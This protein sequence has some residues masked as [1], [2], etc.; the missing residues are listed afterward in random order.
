MLWTVR[1]TCV[2]VLD[3]LDGLSAMRARGVSRALHE[4]FDRICWRGPR[5]GA[6]IDLDGVAFDTYARCVRAIRDSGTAPLWVRYLKPRKCSSV[7]GMLAETGCTAAVARIG[8]GPPWSSS[9]EEAR[10]DANF[11]LRRACW[12]G[13]VGVVRLL[14]GPPWSLGRED[15]VAPRATGFDGDHALRSACNSGNLELLALLAGPPWNLGRADV[16]DG[17][18]LACCANSVDAMRALAGPPWNQGQDDA[19][20]HNLL[21]EAYPFPEVLCELARPPWLLGEADARRDNARVLRHVCASDAHMATL[22]LLGGPPWNLGQAD[23]RA[24]RCLEHACISGSLGIMRVLGEPPWSLGPEDAREL[25]ASRTNW[26]PA[27]RNALHRPPYAQQCP[28]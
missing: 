11:A 13:H 8:A 19:R 28:E 10:L 5:A 20:A 2:E 9:P 27:V 12:S 23:A 3:F 7:L 21:W 16:T 18:R 6:L 1:D 25:L 26:R 4:A 24:S 14:G 17:L 22:R 15:A